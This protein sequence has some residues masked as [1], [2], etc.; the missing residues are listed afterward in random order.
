LVQRIAS[1]AS[2]SAITKLQRDVDSLP[3]TLQLGQNSAML[4]RIHTATVAIT[5]A[6]EDIVSENLSGIERHLVEPVSILQHTTNSASAILQAQGLVA[7]SP[8][9]LS[10][11]IDMEQDREYKMAIIQLARQPPSLL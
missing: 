1:L 9:P 11:F 2:S 5:S 4:S 3:Q 8:M 7:S 6:L 10:S